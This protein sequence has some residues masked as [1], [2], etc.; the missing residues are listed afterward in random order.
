MDLGKLS[1][2]LQLHAFHRL[3]L[4]LSDVP[5]A[6][7][8]E[9][10]GRALGVHLGPRARQVGRV[11]EEDGLH[12]L[13]PAELEHSLVA[14]GHRCNSLEGVTHDGCAKCIGRA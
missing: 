13:L 2:P 1:V 6:L 12:Q 8:L 10:V 4:L 14:A 11:V 5:E 9:E 3:I 7:D